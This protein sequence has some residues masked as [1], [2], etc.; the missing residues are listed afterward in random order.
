[1]LLIDVLSAGFRIAAPL[2]YAAVGETFSE[3]A[4]VLNVQLEAM[5][6]IG[7]FNAV[8]G[9][10][11][12]GSVTVGVACGIAGGAFVALIH[13]LVSVKLKGNQIISGIALNLVVLGLT[14]FLLRIFFAGQTTRSPR[15]LD[16]LT[17]PGLSEIPVL[18]PILF[19]QTLGVYFL[20]ALV[21]ASVYVLSRTSWGLNVTA[22]GENPRAADTV[23]VDVDRTRTQAVLL[24]GVLAGL[25]GAVLGLSGLSFFTDNLTAGRGFIA[26]AAVL[27]GNWRVGWVAAAAFFFGLI[28]AFQL[29]LQAVGV[30]IPP[31]ALNLLPYALTIAILAGVTGRARMPTAFAQ[32][33]VRG[34]H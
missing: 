31:E 17:V 33:Y 19:E 11:F 14:S 28:D 24:A 9:T 3:R 18:G 29:R 12:S 8:L 5:M 23:G 32:P 6:L 22:C 20:Y 30:G 7:A 25:G 21:P 10:Y 4:G 26:L 16:T 2:V 15:G 13:A 1:M 27:F 34:E